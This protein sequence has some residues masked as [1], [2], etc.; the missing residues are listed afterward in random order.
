MTHEV[1][2]GE[3]SNLAN[4][5]V[6]KAL[7]ILSALGNFPNGATATDLAEATKTSRPTVFRMLLSLEAASYVERN[8]STYH[9]GWEL[10]R[11]SRLP[12]L[13]RGLALRVEPILD[14]CAKMVNET[15]NFALSGPDGYFDIVAEGSSHRIL[16]TEEQFIGKHFPPHASSSGKLLLSELPSAQVAALLPEALEKFT[17]RTITSREALQHELAQIKSQGF[18][19]LDGELEDGLYSLSVPVRAAEGELIGAI[20]AYGPSERM[21]RQGAQRIAKQL[22]AAAKEVAQALVSR[23]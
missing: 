8:D 16:T 2:A 9:L 23:N 11:L 6:I 12:H 7:G 21:K 5:S 18:A 22:Q 10:L 15:V 19:V 13:D 14:R 1:P 20:A 3:P 4:K 17:E